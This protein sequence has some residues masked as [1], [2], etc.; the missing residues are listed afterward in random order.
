MPLLTRAPDDTLR[1]VLIFSCDEK[2]DSP[3]HLFPQFPDSCLYPASALDPMVIQRGD[4]ED[5]F[6]VFIF[7]GFLLLG[8]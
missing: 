6:P 3:D 2:P 7:V 4:I 5:P 8:C 1:I